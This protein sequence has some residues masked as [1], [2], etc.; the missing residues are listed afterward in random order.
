MAS[1]GQT[2]LAGLQ[3]ALLRTDSVEQFLHEL[4]VLAVRTVG[5]G[6]PGGMPLSGQMT[7]RQPGRPA[8]ATAGSD[9]LASAADQLESQVG[10][11]P[12]ADV[13]RDLRPV[14]IDDTAAEHRPPPS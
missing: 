14:H 1:E 3:N 10:E 9:R 7:V 8:S 6:R 5:G 2:D 11:G 12:V 4:A 13:P